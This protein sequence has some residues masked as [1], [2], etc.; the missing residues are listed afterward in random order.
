MSNR[1]PKYAVSQNSL[2]P[3]ALDTNCWGYGRPQAGATKTVKEQNKD[4]KKIAWTA[5]TVRSTKRKFKSITSSLNHFS[6]QTYGSICLILQHLSVIPQDHNRG[7]SYET[8]TGTQIGLS[9]EGGCLPQ[10][11]RDLSF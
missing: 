5:I 1:H 11:G 7:L 4:T 9:S 2:Q 3:Q 8:P 10:K 6:P